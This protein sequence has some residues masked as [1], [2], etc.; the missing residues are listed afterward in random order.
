MAT[1]MIGLYNPSSED[2]N[3]YCERFDEYVIANEIKEE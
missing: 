3:A 2:W 1:L